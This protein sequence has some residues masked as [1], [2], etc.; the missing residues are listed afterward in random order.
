[1]QF[2]REQ[3]AFLEANHAAAMTTLRADGS[4]HTVRCGVALIDDKLWS[5]GVPG[6][7]R[8]R[9][10]SRDPRATVMVTDQRYFYLTVEGSIRLLDGPEA[11]E[12]SVRLFRTMQHRPE[13]DSLQW[14][15]QDL[16][17]DQFRQAMRD[18]GRL[19]YELE[20]T[21]A[22]GMISMPASTR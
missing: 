5:S 1:M 18:E 21:R 17:I 2:T 22:Y 13:G 3:R 6:R 14:N 9:H 20:P 7:V 10:V 16:S 8:T 15:G 12:E 11:V 19:I 4:P